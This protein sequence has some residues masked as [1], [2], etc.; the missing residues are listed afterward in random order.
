MKIKDNLNL[1]ENNSYLHIKSHYPCIHGD[2]C[3]SDIQ[4]NLKSL[5]MKLMVN[6]FLHYKLCRLECKYILIKHLIYHRSEEKIYI[7]FLNLFNAQNCIIDIKYK[8]MLDQWS[9]KRCQSR[10]FHIFQWPPYLKV[11]R[12]GLSIFLKSTSTSL[13]TGGTFD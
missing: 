12:P 9:Q 11:G 8:D 7:H 13:F 2:S 10:Y 3:H 1:N 4:D 6:I 5:H